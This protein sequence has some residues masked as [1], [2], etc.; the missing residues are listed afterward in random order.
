MAGRTGRSATVTQTLA[1]VR[2]LFR[3]QAGVHFYDAL[4]LESIPRLVSDWR[5]HGPR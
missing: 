2:L 4:S 3:G 1:V 5:D